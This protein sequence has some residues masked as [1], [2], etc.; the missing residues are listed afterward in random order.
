MS[1]LLLKL[2]VRAQESNA[3]DIV[4]FWAARVREARYWTD[5][6]GQIRRMPGKK[7][8]LSHGRKPR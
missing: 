6:K 2:E 5:H 4:R 3:T 8:I 7:P 1:D